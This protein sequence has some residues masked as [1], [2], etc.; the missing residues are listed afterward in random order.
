[1]RSRRDLQRAVFPGHFPHRP[2]MPGVMIIEALAQTCGILAFKTV[3]VVPIPIRASIRRDRQRRAFASPSNRATR[4][5]SGDP[6]ARLQ[7]DLEVRLPCEV[8]A[9]GGVGGDHGRA[10]T[11]VPGARASRQDPGSAEQRDDRCARVVSPQAEIAADAEVG[12][13]AY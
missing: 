2:L 4:S 7:G 10:E 11:K 1:M 12:R 3:E 5:I 13:S 6:Q 9:R 8:D